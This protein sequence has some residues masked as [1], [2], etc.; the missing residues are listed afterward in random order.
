[1]T[2]IAIC[3]IL[4]QRTLRNV[5]TNKRVVRKQWQLTTSMPFV[6]APLLPSLTTEQECA[7]PGKIWQMTA[8]DAA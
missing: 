8:R 6:N 2:D 7:V 5:G 4:P 1:V 3:A